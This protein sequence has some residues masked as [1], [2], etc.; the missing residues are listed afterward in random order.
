MT[1][2]SESFMVAPPAVA[3]MEDTERSLDVASSSAIVV[4][5]TM[6]VVVDPPV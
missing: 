3:W 2:S 6:E 4:L 1:L 5:N